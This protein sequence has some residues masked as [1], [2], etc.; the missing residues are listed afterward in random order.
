MVNG[1]EPKPPN[2]AVKPEEILNEST[3]VTANPPSGPHR[4]RHVK[5]VRWAPIAALDPGIPNTKEG[6][7][8]CGTHRTQPP[9][10]KPPPRDARASGIRG[11]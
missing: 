9:R 10:T 7:T 6:R 3:D 8:L 4:R 5:R 11:L 2:P 1:A